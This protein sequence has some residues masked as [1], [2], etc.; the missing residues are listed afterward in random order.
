[1]GERSASRLPGLAQYLFGAAGVLG[2]VSSPGLCV[3]LERERHV[4]RQPIVF[5]LAALA[6]QKIPDDLLLHLAR[7]ADIAIGNGFSANVFEHGIDCSFVPNEIEEGIIRFPEFSHIDVKLSADLL[8]DAG[9]RLQ[10]FGHDESQ[11]PHHVLVAEFVQRQHERSDP[12][13]IAIAA[14]HRVAVFWQ[15]EKFQNRL[16][17]NLERG[18][19]FDLAMLSA[20]ASLSAFCGSGRV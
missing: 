18:L 6:G 3:G 9:S 5:F 4:V 12:V 13:I 17:F 20:V 10:G 15:V 11:N 8:N 7:G 2:Q 16:A 19:C 1:M 14:G